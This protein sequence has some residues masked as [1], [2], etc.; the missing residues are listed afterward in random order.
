MRNDR[1][2]SIAARG[3]MKL[4][5]VAAMCAA[6]CNRG[7][8]TTGQPTG[9][10]V[11]VVEGDAGAP[12]GPVVPEKEP[13]D[14]LASAQQLVAPAGVFGHIDKPRDIDLYKLTVAGADKQTLQVQLS[15]VPEVDLALDVLDQTGARIVGVNDGKA[16][17]PEA[18]P[19]GT[20]TP[21]RYFLPGRGAP[22]RARGAPPR[23]PPHAPPP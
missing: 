5:A 2:C 6:A 21:P 1:T 3:R 13:N 18:I 19:A 4:F 9:P 7:E 15:G 22:A 10:A 11:V 17:E 20:P 14:Q 8:H 12:A 16:G 23:R